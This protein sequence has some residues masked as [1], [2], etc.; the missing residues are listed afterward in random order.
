MDEAGV[1]RLWRLSQNAA[2]CG[3]RRVV[4]HKSMSREI[5]P[6]YE[7]QYLFPRSLEEWVGPDHPARFVREFVDALDCEALG[8]TAEQQ[9]R[10]DDPTGR[11]HYGV[12]LLL[13]V[14]LYAYM[15]RI[16][17]SRAVEQACRDLLPMAWLAGTHVPDHNTLWR[18]WSRYRATI[19]QLFVQ[20]VRVAMQ[21]NLVGMVLHAVDGSKIKSAS[22]KRTAWHADDLKHVL[23]RVDRQIDELEQQI[24]SA[25]QGGDGT[26]DRLPAELQNRQEL[27]ARIKSAL[28]ALEEAERKHMHP[29]DPGAGMM[30]SGGRTEFAYNAQVAVD[31]KNGIIVAADVTD[32]ANDERQLEPMLEQVNE[33]TNEFADVT[34]ADSGYHTAASLGAAAA[35]GAEV[36]VATRE[37]EA[38]VGPFH[39]SRFVYESDTDSVVCPQGQRLAREGTRRHRNKP[40]DLKTYRCRVTGTCP[41]ASSCSRDRRGRVI[42]ISP[43]H[44]AVVRNRHHPEARR[45]LRHRQ[46]VVER[47]FAEIK[48]TLGMRRWSFRGLEAVKLQWAMMCAAMNLRRLIAAA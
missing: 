45:L 36:L 41:V 16:R 32:E 31:Q 4:L 37:R 25:G 27:R 35:M 18:F 42:E 46:G 23:A 20:S 38:E 26:D 47:A 13:K 15:N 30:V 43:H 8:I 22:S 48:E 11:P 28:A 12:T 24:C 2:R 21:Q 9:A 40:H 14:W 3:N 1:R 6:D 10:R 34:V 44:D 5:Q 7:T 17:S 19:R 39:A 29:L 33:N